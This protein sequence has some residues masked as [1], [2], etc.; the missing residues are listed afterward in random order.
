MQKSNAASKLHKKLFSN[1]KS[2]A[3][4]VSAVVFLSLAGIILAVQAAGPAVAS[5]AEDG[6]VTREEMIIA[7][8]TASQSSAILFGDA[9]AGGDD[10]GDD[11]GG[12]D[13][14]TDNPGNPNASVPNDIIDLTMWKVTLPIAGDG[15][16]PL[17]IKQPE[18]A[19]YSLDPYFKV[20]DAKNAIVFR[21]VHGGNTTQNSKNP[22]S[23]LRE[24][25]ADGSDEASWSTSSGTHIMEVKTKVTH[26]TTVKPHVVIAQIHGG[27][28]DLTVFRL[29][30][31][32]L[33]ITDGD[34]THGYLVKDNYELGTPISVKFE[35]GGGKVLYYV[36]G[37]KVDYELSA[38]A[39]GCYF[40][41]GNYLQSNPTSAPDEQ[42]GAYS[43]VELS[44]VKVTHS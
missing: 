28:D 33:W 41:A 5:E 9:P 30:G 29:E 23:E 6:E 22:R 4:L 36:D 11:D 17:E 20:N 12:D 42:D 21:A 10:G 27:G 15:D 34:N 26:L 16:G 7:D 37:Q 24:M 13:G 8:A 14:G 19:T 32:S 1:N 18:L 39:D 43:E 2:K 40:K 38:N 31:K 35:A 44:D 3:F 25:N